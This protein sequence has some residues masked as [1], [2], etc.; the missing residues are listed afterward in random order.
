MNGAADLDAMEV[1]RLVRPT[2][3]SRRSF[4]AKAD[5]LTIPEDLGSGADKRAARGRG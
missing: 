2:P 3:I 1:P 4:K 5:E